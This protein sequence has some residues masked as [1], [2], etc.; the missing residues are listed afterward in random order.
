MIEDSR[1]MPA[2]VLE[3]AGGGHVDVRSLERGQLLVLDLAGKL[4]RTCGDLENLND[5]L[6]DF[7]GRGQDRL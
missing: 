1:K 3:K 5:K 7:C 2:K 6:H 4:S